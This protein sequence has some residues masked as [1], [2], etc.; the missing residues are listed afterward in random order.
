MREQPPLRL[1]AFLPYR[2]NRAAALS[3]A[4]LSRIYRG[5]FGLTIP[6]WRVLATLGQLGEATATAIGRHS[7]MHK[8]KVSRAVAS[9]QERRWL[10]R[11]RDPDDRRMEHLRLTTAGR[12]AYRR[13]VPRMLAYQ[14]Q[15]LAH[16]AAAD[17]EALLRGFAALE[18]ILESPER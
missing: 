4:Q 3:S 17:R 7:S 15:V 1:E 12:S 11:R 6:E 5:A 13:L 16:M 10:D 18:R 2:L 14:E 8:T 9:L